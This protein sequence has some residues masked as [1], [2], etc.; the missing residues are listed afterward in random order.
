M[1][2]GPSGK[3]GDMTTVIS[4]SA[5]DRLL[6]WLGRGMA[7][8]ASARPAARPN[9]AD[10]VEDEPLEAAERR[11]SV[12]LMRVNHVGEVCA[13]A[14]YEGQGAVTADPALRE[15]F[16]RAAVEEGDHLAWT[17]QRLAEL[18]GRPSV[19]N[20]LWYAGAFGMGVL[21]GRAG[22]RLSLGFMAETERQVEQHL[23]SHLERLPAADRRSR[24]ILVQMKAEEAAHAV[25]ARHLGGAE[26]A[27][28][29]RGA[30]RLASR[31]MT[32]T[33]H[34]L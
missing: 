1:R 23:D 28:P 14:L 5:A 18:G 16:R 33:A 13:Q 6:S 30:M 17:R 3:I 29:V 10:R 24:A 4:L 2:D 26:L 20:P 8:V 31:V 25:A 19:L 11:L 7:S 27:P 22:D 32:S 21:A 9:P 12:A 34:H 15:Q